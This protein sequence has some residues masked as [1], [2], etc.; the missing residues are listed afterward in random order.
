MLADPFHARSPALD[1]LPAERV[2]H[3]G[4]GEAGVR[5]QAG[6]G[7]RAEGVAHLPGQGEFALGEQ[8]ADQ[9]LVDLLVD[10]E[11]AV[12]HAQH[13]RGDAGRGMGFRDRVMQEAGTPL[14]GTVQNA[15]DRSGEAGI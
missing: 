9:A 2:G 3:P 10:D 14:L 5:D 4:V 11:A 8:L 7:G 1:E 13:H 12:P 6:T 15:G